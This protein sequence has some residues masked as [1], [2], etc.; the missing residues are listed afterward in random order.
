MQICDFGLAK[1]RHY[2]STYTNSKTLRGTITHIA[3]ENWQDI[4]L[5]RGPKFDVYGF[6]IM[7]WQLLTEQLPFTTPDGR[8]GWFYVVT[9]VSC[10][11]W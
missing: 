9:I 8:Q 1:W 5:P 2:S 11:A 6:G 10:I 3:P 4:N 7:F